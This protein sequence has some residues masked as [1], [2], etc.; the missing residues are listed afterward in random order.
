MMAPLPFFRLP[1]S[2]LHPFDH[3]SLDVAG[4]FVVIQDKLPLKRW[5]LV[6]RCATT[7]EVHLEMIDSMDMSSF[8]LA[9]ER[10][11]VFLAD[12]GTNFPNFH[13]GEAAL[14]E[15][16]QINITEAQRKLNIKF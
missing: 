12:N 7:G 16:N 8:F 4:T 15:K 6:I 1:S 9:I 2:R 13:G 5:L 10:F 14:K 11:I 3:S